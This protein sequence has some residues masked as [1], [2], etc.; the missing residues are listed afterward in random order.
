MSEEF[1]I[2]PIGEFIDILGEV[3]D[4]TKKAF[5]DDFVSYLFKEFSKPKT[6]RD[7]QSIMIKILSLDSVKV[8]E[9]IEYLRGKFMS[10]SISGSM[11]RK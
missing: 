7:L 9:Y 11:D 6:E 8:E 3:I 2:K 1:I 5:G 10:D 4:T